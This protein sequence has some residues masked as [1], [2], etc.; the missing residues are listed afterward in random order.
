[1]S[2]G[3]N[4]QVFLE[5]IETLIEKLLFGENSVS[6]LWQKNFILFFFSLLN[7]S[8]SFSFSLLTLETKCT[9]FSGCQQG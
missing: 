2:V 6:F 7:F 8:N 4:E 3:A 9:P 1:M 5:I